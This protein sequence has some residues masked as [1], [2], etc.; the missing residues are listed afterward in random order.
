MVDV[1]RGIYLVVDGL[2]GQVA[3]ERAAD[4]AVNIIGMRLARQ[5]GTPEGRV[6]EAFALASTE[7]FELQARDPELKGMACVATLALIEKYRVVVGHVGDSRLYLLE[8]GSM[9][10]VTRDHSP[11]G[12]MEDSGELGEA[13]AMR[14]SA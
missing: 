14:S 12:E 13:A 1:P 5:T 3:G 4:A 7:I 8:P 2:G 10:K 6:R 11:V 9:R